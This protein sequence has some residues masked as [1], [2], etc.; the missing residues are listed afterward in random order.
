MRCLYTTL[1][2]DRAYLHVFMLT[3]RGGGHL[4]AFENEECP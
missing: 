1:R 3:D 2:S 4:F